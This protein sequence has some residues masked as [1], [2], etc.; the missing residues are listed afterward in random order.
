MGFTASSVTQRYKVFQLFTYPLRPGG[1]PCQGI[2][3]SRARGAVQP[4][5]RSSSTQRVMHSPSSR[6]QVV[7]HSK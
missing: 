2:N 4:C 6:E 1:V 7:M 5:S 3:A